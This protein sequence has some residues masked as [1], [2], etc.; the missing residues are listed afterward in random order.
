MQRALYILRLSKSA[1]INAP[2]R[3]GLSLDLTA[4]D[5]NNLSDSHTML[6]SRLVE[7]S[8][9]GTDKATSRD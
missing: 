4:Q 6:Y 1:C 3:L 7:P 2:K 8:R 5:G 9:H